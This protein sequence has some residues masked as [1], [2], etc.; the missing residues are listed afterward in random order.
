MKR[1]LRFNCVGL[2]G[3]VVQLA[4]LA[5]LRDGLGLHYLI[6]TAFAVE[7]AVLHNFWWHWKWTWVE[8]GAAAWSLL[9]FQCTTGL[10]SIAGNVVGMKALAGALG[11]PLLGANLLTIGAMHVFNFLVADRWVFRLR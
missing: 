6:A 10:I 3:I 5:L 9:H 4:M 7:T 11:L 1:W 2:A 8:R